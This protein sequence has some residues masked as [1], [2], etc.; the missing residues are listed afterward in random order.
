MAAVLACGEGAVLS[1]WDAAALL[2]ML[3]P[4]DGPTHVTIASSGGR[5]HRPGIRLHRCPSLP[6]TATTRRNGIAVTTP[7]RTIADLRRVASTDEVQRAI[8]EAEFL[9]LDLGNEANVESERARTLLER[10]FLRLCRR[11][12]LPMPEVNVYV[13]GYEVDFLW[14]GHRLVVETDGWQG[15]RGRVAFE[16]DRAKDV[17]LKLLGYEV[18]R[19]TYR[20]LMER[21]AEVAAKLRVLLAARK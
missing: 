3:A 18:V 21:P 4:R 8:R 12:R 20:Q 10:R 16:A 9:G 7:A 17:E 2:A 11:Y 19:F 6:S 15:H 14:P 1:H 13:G 5:R